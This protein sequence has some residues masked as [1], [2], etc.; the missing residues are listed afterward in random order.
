MCDLPHALMSLVRLMYSTL[1]YPHWGF[2]E[3]GPQCLSLAMIRYRTPLLFL[4]TGN[5]LKA[6]TFNKHSLDCSVESKL[7]WVLDV[8]SCAVN[9][10]DD[11][12][13]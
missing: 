6:Q 12:F 4:Q 9:R 5:V 1:P 3:M 2:P 11:L 7:P 8:V 13:W 10:D